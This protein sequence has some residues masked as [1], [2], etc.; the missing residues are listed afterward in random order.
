MRKWLAAVVYVIL[1]AAAWVNKE[2]LADWFNHRPPAGSMLAMATLLA[3]CPVIPYKVVVGAAGFM[4]GPWWGAVICLI[5]STTAGVLVYLAVAYAYREQ[6]R[7]WLSKY[8]MLGRYT[9]YVEKH[10][11]EAIII[12]RV[13]PLLPQMAVNAFA[14]ITRMRLH[15]FVLGSAIGKLPGIFVYSFLGGTVFKDPMLAFGIMAGYL[16]FTGAALWGY[17]RMTR[18]R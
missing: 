11:L 2:A 3:L 15:V 12:M 16:L 13:I 18:V 1:L 17:K 10:P 7:A 9:Q 8:Q 4:Y 5:G 6:A 14:G